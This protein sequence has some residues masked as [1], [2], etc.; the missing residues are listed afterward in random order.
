MDNIY[1]W[2]LSNNMEEKCT[3]STWWEKWEKVEKLVLTER[4]VTL[5]W[6][7]NSNMV[8]PEKTCLYPLSLSFYSTFKRWSEKHSC[9]E[10]LWENCIIGEF[11]ISDGIFINI[12]FLW[13]R[14][15]D[16]IFKYLAAIYLLCLFYIESWMVLFIIMVLTKHTRLCFLCCSLCLWLFDLK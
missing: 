13:S 5:S 14:F 10:E 1:F 8:K 4:K 3:R 16:F 2:G 7:M 6:F 12:V 15:C 9:H 11:Y